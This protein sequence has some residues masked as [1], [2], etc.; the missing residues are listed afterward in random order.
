MT[1]FKPTLGWL[2]QVLLILTVFAGL[3]LHGQKADSTVKKKGF[4]VLPAVFYSPET[5]LGFGAASL[6][7]FRS[8]KNPDVRPSNIQNIFIYTLESQILFTNRYNVFL[9]NEQYWINGELGFYVYPYEYYGV[10]NDL[11]EAE[12]Y[13]ADFLRVEINA[14]RQ[15]Q[16]DFYLGPT[17]FYDHYFK[18]STDP[19]GALEGNDVLGNDP[20]VLMGFGA[21]FILDKRN[22]VFCPYQGYYLEGR[23]LKYE[24]SL[25]G[26]YA[27]TDIFLDARKYFHVGERLETAFQFYQQ[28]VL[29]DPPFY[30]YA[31]MGGSKRMRGYYKGAYRDHH[32]TVAQTELRH[33]IFD[34]VVLSAFG[35]LGAVSD[36]FMQYEKLLGS[37]GVGLRYEINSVERIRIRLDYARGHLTDGFY[38]NI[39]EAF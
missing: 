10:G 21:S 29:G 33:Y 18:I 23:L 28:S 16:K 11:N 5:S 8:R 17:L 7:Y 25:I 32:F 3:N 6:T 39:N 36:N 13:T 14:L 12:F 37:Y 30:N 35:G 1:S 19:N 38:I 26:D 9:N 4:I 27:F 31:L 22:N 15:A 20:G 2:K 24:K 34:K